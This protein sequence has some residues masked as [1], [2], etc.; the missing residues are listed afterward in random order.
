MIDFHTHILHHIDDGSR[1]IEESIRMLRMSYDQGIDTVVLTSHFR[2]GEHNIREFLT[3]RRNRL[4]EIR[5][6]LT[7]EDRTRIPKMILASEV[8]YQ[9][10][11]NTWDYLDQ[12]AINGT[13]YILTEMPFIP[14]SRSVVD[15]IDDIALHSPLTPILPHID[16]YFYN[17]TP[18][19]Y[20]EHYYAMPEVLIQ[21]NAIFINNYSNIQF[22]MP[23]LESRK[24]HL[25][26]SDCHG[27]EWRPPNLGRSVQMLQELGAWDILEEIDQRGREILKNAIYEEI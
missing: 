6:A 27:Y 5:Q 11:M 8:E 24:I 10:G 25:L 4:D 15:T 14:W 1:N 3:S 16:R 2:R 20:I 9:P 21:M 12:L 22:F 17:F 18:H 23:L 7:P 26:G 19:E 13:D